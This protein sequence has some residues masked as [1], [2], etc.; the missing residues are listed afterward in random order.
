MPVIFLGNFGKL[1]HVYE[2]WVVWN[3]LLSL[4]CNH[5]ASYT[6]EAWIY[7]A[8]GALPTITGFVVSF[9]L[10]WFPVIYAW[11][12]TISRH[13]LWHK[14]FSTPFYFRGGKIITMIFSSLKLKNWLLM[15]QQWF[16]EAFHLAYLCLVQD[17][18]IIIY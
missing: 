15:F 2:V 9:A 7:S 6:V 18:Q 17:L 13:T 16:N 12:K 8:R 3:S 5:E 1:Q 4:M 14:L 10:Y 11:V